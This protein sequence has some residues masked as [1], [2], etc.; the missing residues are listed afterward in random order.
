MGSGAATLRWSPPFVD[1]DGETPPLTDP[2]ARPAPVSLVL[3]LDDESGADPMLDLA[4]VFGNPNPVEVELGI[5]K[6][7]FLLDAAQRRPAVNY[8]GVEQAGKYLRLAC[9]RAT[10]RTLTNIRFVHGD[11]RE[12]IEFFLPSSSVQALHLNFPDPWPK[13]KHHKRRLVDTQFAEEAHRVLA[14]AGRLWLATDHDDYYQAMLDALSAFRGRLDPVD[15]VW[16]GVATNYEEKFIGQGR[17][18]HRLAFE[19]R[20]A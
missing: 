16:D 20:S 18:I 5:G 11:A 13:K 1:D 7:R 4:G 19:K 6:G 10:K 9:Q 8:V 2:G 15:A 17:R 12:F 3:A 14:P